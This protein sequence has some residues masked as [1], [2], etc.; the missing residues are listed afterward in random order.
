MPV[1]CGLPLKAPR[2]SK[3]QAVDL[4]LPGRDPLRNNARLFWDRR[5]IHSN[6]HVTRHPPRDLQQ[7]SLHVDDLVFA[8]PF[9]EEEVLQAIRL[10]PDRAV[11]ERDAPTSS[12]T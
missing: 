2:S 11:D 9:A 1:K 10:E 12:A 5:G 8:V 7:V 6:H 3:Q 4:S